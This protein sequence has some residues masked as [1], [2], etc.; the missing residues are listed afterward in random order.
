MKYVCAM[1]AVKNVKA[2]VD[3]YVKA[4][5]QKVSMDLGANVAFEG[6]FAVL[7]RGLWESVLGG[8]KSI[9]KSHNA[10][11]Y[12]EHDDMEGAALSSYGVE[13]LHSLREQPWRQLVVRVYD[14]DGHIV[15]IGESMAALASR[16]HEEGL[17]SAGIAR[18]TSLPISEV[19][20]LLSI[21]FEKS[22]LESLQI[23]LTNG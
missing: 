15:E 17:D 10:E 11:L 4:L 5:G 23:P 19:E 20:R 13:F 22:P 18:A 16:L 1:L 7:E 2:S 12:F 21:T 6:G 3:F 8:K 14:P 9:E